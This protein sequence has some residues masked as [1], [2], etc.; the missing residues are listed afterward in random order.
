MASPSNPQPTPPPVASPA[1]EDDVKTVRLALMMAQ[2]ATNYSVQTQMYLR[3]E[4]GLKALDRLSGRQ[5]AFVAVRE[6][7]NELHEAVT[8]YNNQQGNK[9][10]DN[11][12]HAS[13]RLRKKVED[14]IALA[15]AEMKGEK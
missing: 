7:L 5:A 8:A 4:N 6:A 10:S 13:Y 9:M 3:L 15:E 2:G 11:P 12:D 14:A 1:F